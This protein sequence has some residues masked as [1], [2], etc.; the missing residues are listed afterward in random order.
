MINDDFNPITYNDFGGLGRTEH[1]NVVINE[2]TWNW[3]GS[4]PHSTSQ[5]NR[6]S[7]WTDLG[8]RSL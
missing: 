7:S 2:H 3:A 5:R 1:Y 4:L 8:K 6:N